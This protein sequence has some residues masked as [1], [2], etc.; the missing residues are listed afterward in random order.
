V[1]LR[2][3][4]EL[5][6]RHFA[7]VE[8][9]GFRPVDRFARNTFWDVSVVY[10]SAISAIR[11]TCSTEFRC[12]EVELL[13]LREGELPEPAVF[14][15][16]AEPFDASLLDNVVEARAPERLGAPR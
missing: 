1:K 12:A 11:V 8:D 7:F 14:Y 15:D 9:H 10:A 3:W 2:R 6:H 5:V 13:R 4:A 16:D